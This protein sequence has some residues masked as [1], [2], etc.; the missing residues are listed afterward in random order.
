MPYIEIKIEVCKDGYLI[1]Q[2]DWSIQVAQCIA[3]IEQVVE[4]GESIVD[5]DGGK[6][7][8][9]IMAMRKYYKRH[10]AS[11]LISTMRKIIAKEFGDTIDI[12]NFFPG[13]SRMVCRIAGLPKQT[14]CPC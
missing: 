6:H 8:K 10:K 1:N 12:Y 14:S 5:K 2:S 7:W 4:P 13:G 3:E 11:P 9:I